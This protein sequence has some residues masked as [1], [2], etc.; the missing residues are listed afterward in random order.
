[1]T[2]IAP[3]SVPLGATAQRG[4]ADTRG[5]AVP[6]AVTRIC[7]SGRSK[8]SSKSTRGAALAKIGDLRPLVGRPSKLLKLNVA[9]NL[10]PMSPALRRCPAAGIAGMAVSP[11][12]LEVVTGD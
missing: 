2:Y 12:A 7:L 3:A 1:M 11:A 4:Q 10:G 6:V 5:T 8:V 9:V